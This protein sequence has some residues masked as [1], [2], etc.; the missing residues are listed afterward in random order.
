MKFLFILFFTLFYN[1]IVSEEKIF[2]I[3]TATNIYMK[4][5][6]NSPVIY[7][8]DHSKELVKKEQIIG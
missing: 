4:P 7:Q 6:I 3:K 2:S 5:D 1:E 8:F